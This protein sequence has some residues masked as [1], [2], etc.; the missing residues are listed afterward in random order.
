MRAL[1]DWV[2]S[3]LEY[4][5]DTEPARVFQ[6]WTALSAIAASLRK[7][8]HL[9]LGRLRIYPNMYVVF[10]AEPGVA[11]KSQAITFG[12]EIMSQ[13][14]EIV[15]SADCVTKEALIQDLQT[16]ATQKEMMPDGTELTH[17][18]MSIISK[19]FE[20]FLGQKKENTKMLV[21]L[22][23]LFDANE[24]PWKYRTKHSGSNDV[25]SLYINLLGA[26][27]PESLASCLPSTA[28]G[29]GLTSRILFIWADKKYKKVPEPQETKEIKELRVKLVND[30]FII[31]RIV[32]K[33]VFHDDTR[34]EW[35]NWYNNYEELDNNRI[36]KDPSFNGW[37]SRKP[38]YI[39]KLSIIRAAAK[40]N[41]L[42]LKWADV[43]EAINLIEE[44][45][46]DMSG[47]FRA[48]GRSVIT[49]E[50]DMIFKI[51]KARGWITEKQLVEMTW[52]DIDSVKF[53]NV[54]NTCTKSGRIRREFIG[55]DGN[56][57]NIWYVD[58]RCFG[59]ISKKR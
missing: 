41:N 15:M 18:S 23:D 19:E 9:G 35:H 25:P 27:T 42:V 59:E 47:V 26:T 22:T 44:I 51:I 24:L 37:Y 34:K 45:E 31:S 49:A 54:I 5:E 21:L 2:E 6:K 36:C 29:G 55:P 20:S 13:V 14:P 52:R 7:K 39:L 43:Q 28:I 10:V 30:L 58:Q 57:G 17:A 8:V 12:T 33:Y 50:V 11:R 46:L 38:M 56:R 48:I 1:K 53:D 40:S 16:C 3:Y 4:T 32:G